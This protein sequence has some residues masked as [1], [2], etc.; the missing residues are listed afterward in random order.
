MA[1]KAFL[2]SYSQ[3]KLYELSYNHHPQRWKDYTL[4]NNSPIKDINNWSKEIH[5]FNQDFSKASNDILQLPTN[6]GGIY[7]FYVKGPNLPF[8][9]NYI[10]YIGRCHKTD[11]QNIRKRALEYQNDTRSTIREMMDTWKENLYYRFYSDTDN[12][13]INRH[14]ALLIRAIAPYYNEQIP[15]SIEVQ[16]TVNAF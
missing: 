14:E 1:Q 9:E 4:P 7:I 8:F 12:D 5:Y 16:Q 3:N 6:V 13:R 2:A 15:D 10:L 11:R